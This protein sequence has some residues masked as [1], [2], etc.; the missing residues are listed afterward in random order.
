MSDYDLENRSLDH[1]P[2]RYNRVASLGTDRISGDDT[3]LTYRP[4]FALLIPSFVAREANNQ[5]VKI[6]LSIRAVR[7]TPDVKRIAFSIICDSL[8]DDVENG[9][10]CHDAPPDK[11]GALLALSH[12]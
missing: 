4:A 2:Y 11:A 9:G 12:R 5:F 6:S 1:N 10:F 8:C 7:K 3:S